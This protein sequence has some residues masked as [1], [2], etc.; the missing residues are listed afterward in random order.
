LPTQ[1]ASASPT[2]REGIYELTLRNGARAQLFA[3]FLPS[4]F[5]LAESRANTS[6]DTTIA[7]RSWRQH[8]PDFDGSTNRATK[9][10]AVWE[11]DIPCRTRTTAELP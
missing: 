11:L 5:F 9:M 2:S 8:G 6:P 7:H 1:T 4:V 10:A 3:A